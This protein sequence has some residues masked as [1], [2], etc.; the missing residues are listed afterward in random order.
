M[1]TFFSVRTPSSRNPSYKD[2]AS[3]NT[4]ILHYINKTLKSENYK[5]IWLLASEFVIWI[6]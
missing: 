2:F 4:T 1:S 5:I 3:T 6:P